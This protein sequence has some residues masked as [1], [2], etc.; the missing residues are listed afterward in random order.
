[1]VG[2]SGF[3]Q[4]LGDHRFPILGHARKRRLDSSAMRT[5]WFVAAL[6]VMVASIVIAAI[7]MRLS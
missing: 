5:N 6:V 1:V 2:F 4:E 7:A 3:V